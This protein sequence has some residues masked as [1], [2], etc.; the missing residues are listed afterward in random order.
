M[1]KKILITVLI[2]LLAIILVAAAYLAYV[3]IDYHR[4]PDWQRLTVTNAPDREA[5]T[6]QEYELLSWNVG[7][8]AYSRDYSFFMDGGKFSRAYSEDEVRKNL[9]AAVDL[10][11]AEAP[12]LILFQEVDLDADR[13]W[14]VNEENLLTDALPGYG[15][16]GAVNYDSPYLQYPLFRPHGKS[17]AELLTMTSLTADSACR[18]SLPL[19]D[20]LMKYLDLDRC[21]SITDI[22]VNNGRV[23]RLYNLHLSA[24]TSD[25]TI[26]TRQL[27]QLLTDMAQTRSAGN[28][29]VAGGDFNK[30]L[31]GD[32]SAVFGVSGDL[33]TWAQ[34][35]PLELIPRGIDLVA[36]FDPDSPVPSCR[37]CNIGYEP[38]VSFVLTVDGFLVTDN[39]A[40]TGSRVIDAGFENSDHNPVVLTFILKSD[41]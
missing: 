15:R 27:E 2:L 24:Y 30:D 41:S 37:N 39:V 36:P 13:S 40:V 8:G 25:G 35:V 7:F 28:Y 22:P 3:L 6:G 18:R 16:V 26:A 33:L 19:E 12:D 4:L 29:A 17:L 10:V 5:R 32:S 1:A 9:T 31:L 21:Y 14:H 23:L 38:G 34:P 20:S 11:R